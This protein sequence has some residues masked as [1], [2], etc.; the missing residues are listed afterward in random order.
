MCVCTVKR[1][2]RKNG[3]IRNIFIYDL[4]QNTYTYRYLEV[5]KMDNK[6]RDAVQLKKERMERALAMLKAMGSMEYTKAVAIISFNI[7]LSEYKAR[8][9]L[10][11]FREL[12]K[13][14]VS[15]GI[16]KPYFP[17][18]EDESK[19]DELIKGAKK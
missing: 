9:Y 3:L 1:Y 17:G 15:D 6:G 5:L 12:G 10:R 8:E 18:A 11:M 2:I 7:G 19:I 13:I 14:V 4:H 16:V